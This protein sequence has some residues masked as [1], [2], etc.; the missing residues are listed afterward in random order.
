M[1]NVDVMI[2]TSTP[3]TSQQFDSIAESVRSV[4][5]VSRFELNDR[6]PRF[7]MVDYDPEETRAAAILGKITDLGVDASL[8]AG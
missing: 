1:S 5:G 8:V 6:L 2:H 7:I 3:L 4:K